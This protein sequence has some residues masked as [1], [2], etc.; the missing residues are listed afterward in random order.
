MNS[1]SVTIQIKAIK[2][3]FP[4]VQFIPLYKVVERFLGYVD[5]IPVVVYAAVRHNPIR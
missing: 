4:V 5:E 1:L 2:L 3:Y